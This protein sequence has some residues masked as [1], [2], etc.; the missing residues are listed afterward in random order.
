M[1]LSDHVIRLVRNEYSV[2]GDAAVLAAPP[3]T[4]DNGAS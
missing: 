2:F 1:L 3:G 4:S